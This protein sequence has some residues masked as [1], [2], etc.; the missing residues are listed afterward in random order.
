MVAPPSGGPSRD[1]PVKAP[2]LGYRTPGQP[3][4][5]AVRWP[6]ATGLASYLSGCLCSQ[7]SGVSFRTSPALGKGSGPG[8]GPLTSPD[9]NLSFVRRRG[10]FARLPKE[11]PEHSIPCWCTVATVYL[12]GNCDSLK[13]ETGLSYLTRL[14]TVSDRSWPPDSNFALDPW[15]ANATGGAGELCLQRQPCDRSPK[16]LSEPACSTFP[17]SPERI[18]E[19]GRNDQ[20][21]ARFQIGRAH[22]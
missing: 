7:A 5:L 1:A 21:R 4:L 9:G 12:F 15:H 20:C 8:V 16:G 10:V 17:Q 2:H 6:G 14:G 18:L 11:P 19:A 22:V 13:L 3:P